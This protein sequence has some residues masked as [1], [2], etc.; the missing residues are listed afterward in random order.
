MPDTTDNVDLPY[1]TLDDDPNGPAAVQA[2]A[3][4]AD[5]LFTSLIDGTTGTITQASP[6]T[7]SAGYLLVKLGRIVICAVQTA[8]A[9]GVSSSYTTFGTIPAAFWPAADMPMA[10]SAPAVTGSPIVITK[11]QVTST[12]NL[13]IAMSGTHASAMNVLGVWQSAS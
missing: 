11:S 9:S 12:G 2:L 10:S 3:E 6:F 8:R 5:T 1:P 7:V 4:A 13:Q